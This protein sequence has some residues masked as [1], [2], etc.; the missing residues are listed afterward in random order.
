MANVILSVAQA[1]S[2]DLDPSA[3]LGMTMEAVNA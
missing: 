2:K 3:S 1:E